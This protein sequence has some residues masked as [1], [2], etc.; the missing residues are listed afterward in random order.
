MF[1]WLGENSQFPSNSQNLLQLLLHTYNTL[2]YN[3]MLQ[4]KCTDIVPVRAHV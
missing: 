2:K 3:G 1:R 4:M